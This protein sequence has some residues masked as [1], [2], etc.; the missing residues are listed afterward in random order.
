MSTTL[1]AVVLA[2]FL[3]H[4]LTALARW[5]RFGGFDR[6]LRFSQRRLPALSG[7][8]FS[9]LLSLGLP[10]LLVG[11]Q[12]SWLDGRLFGLAGFLFA[13]LVLL[14][15]WG[16][17]DLD[18]DVEAVI[19]APDDETRAGA[20]ARLGDQPAV[21]DTERGADPAGALFLAATGRWFGPLLWFLLLGPFG[22]VLYRLTAH[23]VAHADEDTLAPPHRAAYRHLLAI[24]DWPV[25][26]L[27]TLALAVV[28]SFDAIY[29][30]WQLWHRERRD[31]PFDFSIGFLTGAAH[32]GVQQYLQHQSEQAALD[33]AAGLDAKGKATALAN[34]S[35]PNAALQAALTLVWRILVAWLVVVALLV[36]AGYV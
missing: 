3:G 26:H 34:E 35:E 24:L 27:M 19:E 21:A 8:P 2:L 18:R 20:W 9:I 25:A 33:R 16:P 4:V 29:R 13:V 10:L 30:A 7:S 32:S 1:I 31:Q 36:L 15:C 28:G 22:A 5:R 6:W 23:A 17:R 12:Q 14:Y 11:I